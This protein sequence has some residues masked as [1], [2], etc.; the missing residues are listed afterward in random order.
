MHTCCEINTYVEASSEAVDSDR[1]SVTNHFLHGFLP[2]KDPSLKS[3][4]LKKQRS[5]H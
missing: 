2:P 5:K 4:V 3:S 1:F